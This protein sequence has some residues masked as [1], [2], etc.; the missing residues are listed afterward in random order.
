MATMI[1]QDI[2]ERFRREYQQYHDLD[3]GRIKEQQKTLRAFTAFAE[4]PLEECRGNDLHQYMCAQLERG[5]KPTTV[6]KLGN[7]IRPFYTW[8]FGA[9][10]VDADTLLS[11]RSVKNP[12]GAGRQLPRPYSQ[13][14]LRQFRA[15]LDEKYP[16][17]PDYKLRF[18]VS[19]RWHYRQIETHAQRLHMEAIVALALYGGLR[20]AEIY[21]C[22]IVDMHP[23][24]DYVIVTGK[25]DKVREVPHTRR[26]RAAIGTWIDFREEVLRPDHD[27]PWMSLS[28]FAGKWMH[29]PLPWASFQE[30]LLPVG[31]FT[32]H[33]FRHT[34][35]TNWLRAGMPIEKLQRLLG[36]SQIADT[37]IYTEIVKTDVQREVERLEDQ[38]EKQ[39]NGD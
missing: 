37:M 28:R 39:V 5:L 38:F 21:N 26:T 18:Y 27:F 23:D 33:R 22:S 14:E 34:A 24:N 7:M 30:L 16:L 4:K 36:H 29:G 17:V 2:T 6:R 12:S 32:Y 10:V 3:P 11:I 1:E 8:A 15:A 20:R 31:P 25:G 9:G 35:A 13:D 19:G